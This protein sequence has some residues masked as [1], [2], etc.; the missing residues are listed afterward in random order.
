MTFRL[1]TFDDT[2]AGEYRLEPILARAS[3]DADLLA[4]GFESEGRVGPPSPPISGGLGGRPA[5]SA[6]CRPAGMPEGFQAAAVKAGAP[7]SHLSTLLADWH[8]YSQVL[9]TNDRRTPAQGVG[10]LE[11]AFATAPPAPAVV[12]ERNVAVTAGTRYLAGFSSWGGS[13]VVLQ[14]L[15]KAGIPIAE[16]ERSFSGLWWHEQVAGWRTRVFAFTPPPGAASLRLSLVSGE[17]TSWWDGCFLVPA[18]AVELNGGMGEWESGRAARSPI[19]PLSHSPT[20]RLAGHRPDRKGAIVSL[21]EDRET[22][23]NWIGNYGQYAWILCGMSSP[24]DMVGGIAKPLKCHHDDL[25]K[26]YNNETIWVRGK[27]ELRYAAWTSNPKD[28]LVRHWIGA[29]RTEDP[30]AL[31]NPQ[32]G[33]RTYACWDDHGELHPGDGWGPDLFVK[34]QLPKGLWRVSLYFVDWD[35]AKHPF[36]RAQRLAW[37]DEKGREICTARVAGFGG[38]IYKTFGMEGGREVTLRI[39]KDAGVAEGLSGIFLDPMPTERRGPAPADLVRQGDLAFAR[40]DL[41]AAERAY[42]AALAKQSPAGTALADGCLERAKQL[43]VVHPRYAEQK[44]RQALAAVGHLKPN[45]QATWLRRATGE[46]LALAERDCKQEKGLVCTGYRLAEVLLRPLGNVAGA[47]GLGRRDRGNLVLCLRRQ[48]WY[49]LGWED[50]ARAQE[51]LMAA[52]HPGEV[53]GADLLDLLRTYTVLCQ[54]D[55]GYIEKAEG[56]T[57]RLRGKWPDGDHTSQANA[58]MLEIYAY[59]ARTWGSARRLA[60]S[61]LE[62]KPKGP[63]GDTARRWLART[64]P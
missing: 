32:W 52:T 24:R 8:D 10:L 54:R 51:D 33:Y 41:G 62:Q 59:R 3:A 21:G 45:A 23:G 61:I 44:C 15:D 34:V 30:R 38:G 53:S 13:R 40:N 47:Q 12:G 58:K 39:R 29:H 31:E 26:T 7:Y 43:R 4:G 25:S 60:R 42:D 27:E 49:N 63:D 36:P 16:Q 35:W 5:P 22:R 57:E 1:D 56:I 2:P 50:L 28:V 17:K 20:L 18:A 46:M 9:W 6:W 11:T 48:V 37:L 19:L 14:V 64:S 55:E